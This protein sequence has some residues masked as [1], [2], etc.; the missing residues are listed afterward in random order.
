MAFR[1]CR[2][3][4][5]WFCQRWRWQESIAQLFAPLH[6]LQP[7]HDPSPLPLETKNHTRT[8]GNQ[9]GRELGFR[10]EVIVHALDHLPFAKGNVFVK[11]KTRDKEAYTLR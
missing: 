3:I 5:L 7:R 11:L 4:K 10:V 9:S 8:M 6:E 1:A 2:K